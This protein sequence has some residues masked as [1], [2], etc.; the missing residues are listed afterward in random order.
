MCF[1]HLQF[2]TIGSLAVQY[3]WVTCSS[4]SSGL[5]ALATVALQDMVRPFL[6]PKMKDSTAAN[7]SKGIGRAQ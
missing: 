5:N 3:V 1:G 2:N 4:I 6:L 7:V